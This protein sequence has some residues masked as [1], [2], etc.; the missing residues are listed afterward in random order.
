MELD[1]NKHNSL[2]KTTAILLLLSFIVGGLGG[3]IV[4]ALIN[5]DSWD[6][7]W[8]KIVGNNQ[9]SSNTNLVNQTQTI[10]IEEDSATVEVVKS[11]QPS[12][13][14]VIGTQD[15]SEL[16]Q[17]PF[18]FFSF[19]N[20]PQGEQQVSGGS[21]FIIRSDGLVL[22][23]K[24]VVSREG[25]DYSVVLDDGT[26][27]EAT[28]LALD[29]TNDIAFIDIEADNLPAV[30][31]GDSDALAVGQTVIAIGN[32]LGRY[33]NSVTRGIIS[34]L[35][36]T[37]QAG[38]SSGAPETLEDTIQTDAAINQGNSGGPLLNIAGQVVG[39]NTAISASG[40]LVGFAIPINQVKSDIASIENNGK[41]VRPFLG[42]RYLLINKQIQ[43]ANELS[44]D[45]GA[46]VIR[47]SSDDQLAVV[48][49][50]PADI[51][52]L[53]E[54]DIILEI[55]G[56]EISEDQSLARILAEHQPGDVVSIKYI[57]D[58]VEKV[59]ET[60]LSTRE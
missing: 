18:N 39:V 45:H 59:S 40:Q 53:V 60:T 41:I 33:E 31:L 58:G 7:W 14:S 34:G 16:Q 37:I 54:N 10:S 30:T 55:S 3:G 50:S 9:A 52:G 44:I 56:R 4:S 28:V 36:R 47:G 11:V 2:G 19:G 25:V 26:S 27:Y 24:H 17:S 5:N 46:L 13:V 29:P 22:T 51:A 32:V 15:L 43:N 49:G 21:G 1:S 23:N 8:D 6:Q 20:N 12:V 57:H 35:S 38:G 42:I 48:P